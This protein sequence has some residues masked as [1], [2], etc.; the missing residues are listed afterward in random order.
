MRGQVTTYRWS[1][2]RASRRKEC[3]HPPAH[4]P[5]LLLPL[6]EPEQEQQEREDQE[7]GPPATEHHPP[8]E[9]DSGGTIR[10]SDCQ[11][12]SQTDVWLEDWQHWQWDG[13]TGGT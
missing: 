9:E 10:R 6:Q 8:E 1:P 12:S 7:P 4:H 13:K 5:A 3:E 2:L 11:S